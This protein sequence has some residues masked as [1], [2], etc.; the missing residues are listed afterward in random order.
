MII[1]FPEKWS[2]ISYG[3][4]L[5][6]VS[7]S[8]FSSSWVSTSSWSL[9]SSIDMDALKPATLAHPTVSTQEGPKHG[10]V[11]LFTRQFTTKRRSH[12][13][14]WAGSSTSLC[15]CRSGTW[16]VLER[17]TMSFGSSKEWAKISHSS[18]SGQSLS[19]DRLLSHSLAR[20]SSFT[21][22]VSPGNSTFRPWFTLCLSSLSILSSSSYQTT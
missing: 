15:S 19:S 18:S 2:S 10:V 21:Q 12:Q 8:S 6:C 5:G 16:C 11:T 13:D 14:I 22:L 9:K 20:S 7:P 3:W 17:F 4:L 1:S